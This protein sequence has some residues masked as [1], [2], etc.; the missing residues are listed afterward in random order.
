MGCARHADVA[1]VDPTCE[2]CV[3]ADRAERWVAWLDARIAVLDAQAAQLADDQQVVTAARD[4]IAEAL[5]HDRLDRD[6]LLRAVTPFITPAPTVAGGVPVG[7]VPVG[8]VPA[9]PA[10]GDAASPVPLSA[11]HPLSPAALLSAAGAALLLIAAVVFTAVSWERLGTGGQIAV[12]VT[13]TVLA[14]AASVVCQRR[15][16]RWTAEAL[17][18]LAASLAVVDVVAAAAF[19]LVLGDAAPEIVVASSA[20]AILVV[21]MVVA[22]L[23]NADD[24]H[25]LLRATGGAADH[26]VA[27]TTIA[28]DMRA[29]LSGHSIVA[30]WVQ[31][32]LAVIVG[33]GALAVRLGELR[34]A[35]VTAAVA[36]LLVVATL[37]LR[38][39]LRRWWAAPAIVALVV[40]VLVSFGQV[41][42]TAVPL[43]YAT[44][45]SVL[46][47]SL[48]VWAYR[49]RTDP[50]SVPVG[51]V[52]SLLVV[53]GLPL[54]HVARCDNR[55]QFVI[56][57]ALAG[58]AVA[59]SLTAS[60]A[61]RRVFS[62]ASTAALAG[63]SVAMVDR[64]GTGA[65]ALAAVLVSAV[66]WMRHADG[67]RE[68]SVV[69]A[70][71]AIALLAYGPAAAG[72]DIGWSAAIAALAAVIGTA[73]GL[74]WWSRRER[75]DRTSP[76]VPVIVGMLLAAVVAAA[77]STA[78]ALA[79]VTVALVVAATSIVVTST[80]DATAV[81]WASLGAAPAAF[82]VGW[83]VLLA[84]R[85]VTVAESY[86]WPIAA[87]WCAAGAVALRRDHRIRSWPAVG[88]GL[89]VAVGPTAMVLLAGDD[90]LTRMVTLLVL[91][92]VLAVAGGF[93][94]QQAP[95]VIGVAAAVFAA[96]TQAG[97]WATELPRWLS[98]GVVGA[99][100]LVAGAR[101]ESV[102]AGAR[103][104]TDRISHFR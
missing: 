79:F 31:G 73:G 19:D 30:P 53:F 70:L 32:P 95:L 61:R 55:A 93:W 97:P 43:I 13:A 57:A 17:S 44:T 18:W 78:T 49:C 27:G 7:G 69:G 96:L 8:G 39:A 38:P 22:L 62:V 87:A 51:S 50:R 20:G 80:V 9:H 10:G 3:L 100:L 4:E 94:R 66:A 25:D 21:G 33:S 98:L 54:V 35:P 89:A 91:G 47:V 92:A 71:S 72:L 15:R 45:V 90:G 41:D 28:G 23:T 5:E 56:V 85:A 37:R 36:S 81:R 59:G 12:M 64:A 75:S 103:R 63:A 82:A 58:A 77:A 99:M 42:G 26:S 101:F 65:V 76:L 88:P 24:S 16:L 1:V 48:G 102:R 104:A 40:S 11:G 84:E 67:R 52:V 34:W 83:L 86:S 2:E 14:A 60:A 74:L 46:V 6:A 68:A 29:H